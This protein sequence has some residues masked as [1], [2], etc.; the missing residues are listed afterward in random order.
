MEFASYHAIIARA[1]RKGF[2]ASPSGLA[3]AVASYARIGWRPTDPAAAVAQIESLN[4][5]FSKETP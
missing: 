2:A 1:D 4:D 3:P 5:S